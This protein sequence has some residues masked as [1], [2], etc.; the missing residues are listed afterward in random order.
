MLGDAS[1]GAGLLVPGPRPPAA[2]GGHAPTGGG[3][4]AALTLRKRNRMSTL[5]IRVFGDPVL[6]EPA[7][8][9]ESFDGGLRRLSEDMI[10]TMREAPGVGLAAPQVGRSIRLIVFDIGDEA[11]ARALANPGNDRWS[12]PS[13]EALVDSSHQV[14]AVATRVPRPAGRGGA[15]RPTP[16]A[17]A[18]QRLHQPLSEVETVKHGPGFEVLRDGTPDVL[19]VVAYGE[20]LPPEVLEIPRVAPVNLHF[21]LLPALRG[22]DPVR[23]AILQGIETT[24]VT[25]IRMDE[26]MDTG[27][28]LM[29]EEVPITAREDAGS[30]GDRLAVLGGGLLVET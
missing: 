14:V 20:I 29:Q 6:R 28:I 18:A 3:R 15:L 10:Q 22:A 17:E 27:P 1:A 9:I 5:S 21:S 2:R 11:G 8:P 4:A 24:G 19:A 13:L 26:G 25:T 30:L 23:R 12:V 16:V 7:S